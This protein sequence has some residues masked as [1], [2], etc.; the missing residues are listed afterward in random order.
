MTASLYQIDTDG[1]YIWLNQQL[2]SGADW[3]TVKWYNEDIG[4]T[5]LYNPNAGITATC[6][7]K[8]PIRNSLGMTSQSL[9][10][11]FSMVAFAEY[12]QVY[13]YSTNYCG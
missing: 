5:Y 2:W 6:N 11:G 7:L 8:L 4:I 13:M 9:I 3:V 10:R 12:A 1:A